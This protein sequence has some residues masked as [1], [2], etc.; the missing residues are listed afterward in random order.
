[1]EEK[2]KVI[3]G[4]FAL[5]GGAYISAAAMFA[6]SVLMARYMDKDSFGLYLF[7][8]SAASLISIFTDM[9]I[10][11][12]SSYFIMRYK[13]SQTNPIRYVIYIS[14]KLKV[15]LISL[16]FFIL[17]LLGFTDYRYWYVAVFFI[18]L[19]PNSF[20]LLI[21]QS[22]QHFRFYG[23]VQ[24]IESI[25]KLF[26]IYF[27][28]TYITT[29]RI[30]IIIL[31]IILPMILSIFLAIRDTIRILPKENI[32]L[33]FKELKKEARDYWI[34]FAALSVMTP[35]IGNVMQISLGLL[36]ELDMVA[37]F[38]VGKTLSNMVLIFVSSFKTGITPSFIKK[39][40]RK[41]IAF[42]LTD[43]IRYMLMVVIFMAFF[44]HF[45]S[46]P[47]VTLFYTQKYSESAIIFEILSYGTLI[48]LVFAG[49]TPAIT[50]IGKQD[51]RV[52]LTVLYTMLLIIF[53][54]IVVPKYGALGAALVFSISTIIINGSYAILAKKYLNFKF[55]VT[56]LFKCIIAAMLALVPMQLMELSP[57]IQI[58]IT[59]LMGIILYLTFLFLFNEIKTHDINL[60]KESA[61]RIRSYIGI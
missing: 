3:T 21:T 60:M 51:M 1:M 52:K 26:L 25:L 37:V 57:L 50:S 49:V 14:A 4:S 55:P 28:L 19:V 42:A 7:V 39:T 23:Q 2:I 8:L 9:G 56:T 6:V 13:D 10:D 45:T 36:K 48:T 32:N 47:L 38:G 54:F 61:R 53:S 12:V 44:I 59:F 46:A 5:T 29:W 40:D 17:V 27:V 41:S 30:S 33:N 18:I 34:W 43:S 16:I 24:I 31:A 35:V 11:G 58:I 22:F 20:A 15:V